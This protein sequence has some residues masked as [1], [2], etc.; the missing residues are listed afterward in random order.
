[1][2]RPNSWSLRVR[3]TSLVAVVFLVVLT[4][5]AFFFVRLLHQSLISAESTTVAQQVSQIAADTEAAGALLPFDADEVIIQLQRDGKVIAVADADF[6]DTP[7]LP[8]S[9]A[10]RV[11][12]VGMVRFVVRSKTVELNSGPA[13]IAVGRTLAGADEAARSASVLLSIAVPA[14]AASTAV[15]SWLLV[16]RSLRPVERI[17]A[18]VEAIEASDLDRRVAEPEGRDEIARLAR[19][20]NVM[21]ERLDRA[22]RTQRRFVSNASHELRS[23]VAAIRQHAQVAALHPSSM[24]ISD[25]AQIVDNEAARME[26]LVSGL[27]ILARADEF[28][29]GNQREVDLDDLVLDEASRLRALGTTVV[30]TA[31]GPAQVI[32]DEILLRSAVRNAADN[33]RRHARHVVSFSVAQNG[34]DAVLWVD[35]DGPG[36]PVSDRDRVFGRFERRDDARARDS[37]GSGLGL[38]IIAEAARSSRGEALIAEAPL[39][40]ARLEIRI[41]IA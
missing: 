5:G 10:M 22:Q 7:P 13:I 8:I 32:G 41:P 9:D 33:A 23:P 19:T 1:M 14:I 34:N 3:M 30:T 11:A 26:S 38:A 4:V 35:D 16:G 15:L 6:L 39:G 18:D 24:Q 36:V 40:G 20:M 31:V 17:R 27:L 29:G 37:G 25:L 2:G 21:L 12:T 28:G